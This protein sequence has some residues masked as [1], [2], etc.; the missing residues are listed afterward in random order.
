MTTTNTVQLASVRIITE[1]VPRL[2]HF[3]ETVTGAT[4][5]WLTDDFVELVTPSATFALSHPR[6][7][8]FIS[9]NIPRAAANHSAIIEFLVDDVDDLFVRLQTEFGD[10]LTIV[11]PPTMMPWG[12]QSVLLRDPDGTLINLYTPITPNA[13]QLQQQRQP[14]LSQ[15][16]S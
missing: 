7:V 16:R 13:L 9:D 4:G 2:L 6:R 11:Q 8:A 12:N 14:Q 10:D 5:R 1:D 15:Q 3:Y